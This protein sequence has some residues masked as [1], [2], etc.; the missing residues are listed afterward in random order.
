[1][2]M[3]KRDTYTAILIGNDDVRKEDKTGSFVE[4]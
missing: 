4:P 3:N 2:T 1:M